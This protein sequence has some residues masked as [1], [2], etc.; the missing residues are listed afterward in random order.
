MEPGAFSI[1]LRLEAAPARNASDPD[2]GRSHFLSEGCGDCHTIRG[3]AARGTGGPDL[4]HFGGRKSLAAATL[5]HN[6]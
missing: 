3:T 5:P 6:E 4:T 1:W 2:A